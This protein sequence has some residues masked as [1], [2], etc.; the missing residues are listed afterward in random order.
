MQTNSIDYKQRKKYTKISLETKEAVVRMVLSEGYLYK[1]VASLLNIKE[2][3]AKSIVQIYKKNDCEFIT[4]KRG[5][6]N[7][8]KL[9]ND[10]LSIIERIVER[11]P[12]TTLKEISKKV[13]EESGIM[14]SHTTI[15][16]GLIQL[17]ITTKRLSS[18]LDRVNI[19]STLV[20]RADYAMDF[21]LYSP[22]DKSRCIF[23]DESGFNLHLKRNIGRSK[24]GTKATIKIPTVRGRMITLIL[25]MNQCKILNYR[26]IKDGTCNGIKFN[27][28][29]D[30]TVEIINQDD[31][32][33]GSWVIMDNA[34]IH[35]M[36]KTKITLQNAGLHLKYLSPYSYMLN[37]VEQVFSK[38]KIHVKNALQDATLRLT[39]GDHIKNAIDQVSNIDC[40]G[41][42]M[43]MMRNVSMAKENHEFK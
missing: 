33:R 20:K 14:L 42:Y 8:I 21:I 7:K 9:T 36:E 13:E 22:E 24:V 15:Q 34:A 31:R 28:F 18:V 10:I 2:S 17:Q 25:A 11:T 40:M 3:T 26:I 38:I 12:A 39:L 27:S 37:P 19:Q 16:N 35:K 29:I 4:K 5:G 30:E 23:L 41:Y 32:L 1:D 6:N 43:H